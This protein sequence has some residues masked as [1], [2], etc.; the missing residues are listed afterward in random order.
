[1]RGVSIKIVTKTHFVEV[2][3]NAQNANDVLTSIGQV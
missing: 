2:E 1:M 3:K